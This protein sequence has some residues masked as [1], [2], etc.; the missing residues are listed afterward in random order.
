MAIQEPVGPSEGIQPLLRKILRN[1]K[2]LFD[3]ITGAG[4]T[5]PP[6]NIEQIGGVPVPNGPNMPIELGD[7]PSIDAFDRLRV[8]DPVG[9]F[10]STLTYDEQLL[11]WN[12]EITGTATA[13]HLPNE[14]S[15]RMR[16]LTNGDSVV[17]QTKDYFRYQPGKS[18]LIFLTF[19]FGTGDPNVTKRVGYFDSQNGVFLEEI[20]GQIWMVLRSFVSG[21]AVDNRIAQADWNLNT[22]GDFDPTKAHILIIDLEWLGV[23]RVR[24]GFVRDGIVQY[25]HQFVH[26]NI[27]PTVYMSTAQLPLRLETTAGVGFSGTND[28]IGIC[29]SVISEGGQDDNIGFPFSIRNTALRAVGGTPLPLLSIR[30]KTTFNGLTNRV[31]VIQRLF[32]IQNQASNSLVAYDVIYDGTLTGASWVSVD[33]DSVIEYDISATS[34]AGGIVVA[35]GFI[36]STNQSKSSVQTGIT[37]RLPIALD[38][39][40]ANP[41]PLSIRLTNITGTASSVGAFGWQEYR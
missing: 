40:G 19:N 3:G 41:T 26:A 13:T 1:Q 38:I 17:R 27:L 28:F 14:S 9:L 33:A 21:V 34:I 20:N 10:E 25:V 16:V 39:A 22:V 35:S 23:G 2:T 12:Q 29:G 15:I 4:G 7:S 36:A 8:S 11:L 37:G 30:P 24:T 32:E 5:P 6:S 18:Q 31:Q